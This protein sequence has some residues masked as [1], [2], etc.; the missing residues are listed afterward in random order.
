MEICLKG[1]NKAVENPQVIFDP[2][3][4]PSVRVA[5]CDCACSSSP[6]AVLTSALSH[7][8]AFASTP[9][10]MSA[11]VGVFP[12]VNG[13]EMAYSK[14][15]SS[16]KAVLN[17]LAMEVLRSFR[18]PQTIQSVR[19]IFPQFSDSEFHSTVSRL[20]GLSFLIPEHEKT[21]SH[22]KKNDSD[23]LVAWLHITNA[24]NMRCDYCFLRK[25][26]TSMTPQIGKR[27]I[28]AIIRS[29][30]KHGFHRVKIKYAGG[31][32][33][34]HLPLIMKLQEYA[35]RQCSMNGIE[36]QSVIL[37][38]GTAITNSF[39]DFVVSSHVGVMI[40]LDGIGRDNDRQRR[41]RNGRGTYDTVS[42]NIRQLLARGVFPTI[43]VTVTSKNCDTLPEMVEYLLQHKLPFSL[44]FYRDN[45][46]STSPETLRLAE[47]K[48]IQAMKSAFAVIERNIPKETLLANLIDLTN[49]TN[50]HERACGV[51]RNYLVVDQNG[52]I[53]KCHMQI[54]GSVTSIYANDPLQEVIAGKS[55][56]QNPSV[57]E[58]VE[59]R[60]CAWKSWCAGGCPLMTFRRTGRFD[61]KSPNCNIYQ[62]LF[63]EALR[64]EGLRLIKYFSN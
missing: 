32:P 25:S 44:N 35:V 62:A 33:S 50:P 24:C 60:D 55:G 13:Y 22:T 46:C 17:S 15:E 20:A 30:A 5:D 9:L 41:F 42:N 40:S 51:G 45:D 36:L 61:L 4:I 3:L 10:I 18:T 47:G 63:P 31:E 48:I 43:S 53:A 49:L 16:A 38:N 23:T 8:F 56:L 21:R 1:D 29:A 11:D 2:Q 52:S 57:Y 28:D 34:L 7:N 19:H 27:S 14:V 37:S 39:I 12:I 59:C 6:V 64:L 26:P 58:K 54:E